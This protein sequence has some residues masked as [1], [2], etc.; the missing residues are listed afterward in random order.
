MIR[1]GALLIDA[2]GLEVHHLLAVLS[3]FHPHLVGGVREESGNLAGDDLAVFVI[4][5]V[6]G[7]V[8]AVGVGQ[9]SPFRRVYQPVLE[10]VDLRSRLSGQGLPGNVQGRGRVVIVGGHRRG[11]GPRQFHDVQYRDHL[12]GIPL[13]HPDPVPVRRLV[14][15]AGLVLEFVFGDFRGQDAGYRR[16][17]VR[18]PPP[19]ADVAEGG[20]RTVDHGQVF[21]G[22]GVVFDFLGQANGN[23]EWAVLGIRRAGNLHPRALLVHQFTPLA[24][25]AAPFDLHQGVVAPGAPLA[26][27]VFGRHR[28][29]HN[30]PVL[31]RRNR[32][33]HVAGG[34]DVAA[35]RRRFREGGGDGDRA[36]GRYRPGRPGYGEG[37][38]VVLLL[39]LDGYG[40]GG[41]H[42][43]V[44]AAVGVLAVADAHLQGVFVAD[45]Q[46][47]ACGHGYLAG[48][49]VDG[50]I[51]RR[52][53]R[54]GRIA[55]GVGQRVAVVVGGGY[56][57]AYGVAGGR[58]NAHVPGR[59]RAEV[60]GAV[61]ARRFGDFRRF[62]VPS[63]LLV[64]G[65]I[66]FREFRDHL[67]G[68]VNGRR[69]AWL[70]VHYHGLDGE[71]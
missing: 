31:R 62:R 52:L 36:G 37:G 57:L 15:V 35:L 23:G 54:L 12:P 64:I 1:P 44:C 67:D 7:R 27:G 42:R 28:E 5:V 53:G 58:A 14:A 51:V 26:L 32:R 41:V 29:G 46:R 47:C 50:E 70:A 45:G 43:R 71:I 21:L 19:L 66:G 17:D 16:G 4:R 59:R 13:G 49:G 22:K 9:I 63:C 56:R 8:G 25:E 61:A 34:N 38:R 60:G 20:D 55:Q 11:I 33:L 18:L 40:H 65:V 6:D 68:Q 48:G 24:G 30:P 69:R 39:D 2:G 3:P 10:V